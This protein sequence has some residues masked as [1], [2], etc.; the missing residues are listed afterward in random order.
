MKNNQ[1]SHIGLIHL[2]KKEKSGIQIS[3]KLKQ[4]NFQISEW[5]V[6]SGDEEIRGLDEVET[7]IVNIG[8]T[9]FDYAPFLLFLGDKDKKIIINEA[10]AS[11]KISGVRRLSWERHLLNKIDSSF[12]VLPDYMDGRNT[13]KEKVNLQ[14]FGVK[15]LWI[16]AASIGGPEAIQDFLSRFTG[17]EPVLFIILQHINKEFLDGMAK[18]LTQNCNFDVKLPF[19]GESIKSTKCIIYPVDEYLEFNKKGGIELL[20]VT[21][22]SKYTPCIDDCSTLLSMNLENL[23]MAIFSGMSTDGIKAATFVLENGGEVITQTEESCVLSSIIAGV[24]K[25]IDIKFEGRP[26]EMAEYIIN[27]C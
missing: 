4:F 13:K 18:Q 16:L 15:Q 5:V 23:N 9:K 26:K 24:K 3:E 11:N 21:Q 10:S 7:V 2:G 1:N 12:N 19:S 25:V 20:P 27:K 8:L 14:K 22:E 17:N 6:S